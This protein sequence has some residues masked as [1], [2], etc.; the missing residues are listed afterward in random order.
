MHNPTIVSIDD[1]TFIL[2]GKY[3]KVG[4]SKYNWV[5]KIDKDGKRL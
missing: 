4:G 5:W 3:D 2:M 1:G